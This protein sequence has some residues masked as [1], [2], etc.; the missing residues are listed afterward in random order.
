MT[1]CRQQTIFLAVNLVKVDNFVNVQ[2]QNPLNVIDFQ[3][4][5]GRQVELNRMK[6]IATAMLGLAIVIFVVASLFEEQAVWI[7]FVRAAA[8]AAMVG[9]IA[10]WFAV[11]A[12]FRH[13][14]GLKIPHTA[15]IPR[16]K[17]S[18]ALQ[19]GQFVQNNFL[20][21]QVIA[22][23]LRSVDIARSVAVW[24]SAPANSRAVAG[25]VAAVIRGVLQVVRDEDVQHIIER[26]LAAQIRAV[27]VAPLTGSVLSLLL[28]G[29]RQQELLNGIIKVMSGVLEEN[30]ATFRAQIRKET[31]W[32][33]PDAVDNKIYEKIVMGLDNM[34][35][36]V[37]ANPEHPL[38]VK[39][40]EV[41]TSFITDLQTSPELIERGE[42]LKEEFLEN[43]GVQEFASSLWLDLKTSLL[44]YSNNPEAGLSTPIQKFGVAL[45]N[46]PPLLEKINR[47]LEEAVRYLV[48]SYGH[49]VGEM[50]TT[51]I[52]EWDTESTSR[53][54]ELQVGKD[55]QYIRIN[56]T[57]VGGL[58]GLVI[59]TLA[60]LFL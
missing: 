8:E 51:T 21:E 16:R 10:D 41:L 26:G 12:L 6:L 50:I 25:V 14:L 5:Q 49:E 54:I 22:D 13:P 42:Q 57:I 47:W 60:V 19:F 46:D 44:D 59:H 52:T 11:T 31:P 55:L 20:S 48:R 58:V 35:Q 23:R 27:K 29:E 3:H 1:I 37:S 40:N 2:T 7:G 15:I 45:Q 36:E 24:L 34:M 43:P 56:G 9:A 53:K 32:W 18:L 38:Q 17:N 33:L 30:Q 4:D 28:S 39:F